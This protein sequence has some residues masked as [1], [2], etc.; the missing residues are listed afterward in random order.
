[1]SE[2]KNIALLFTTTT[3]TVSWV[4]YRNLHV[5]VPPVF[6]YPP[7]YRAVHFSVP[8]G[9]CEYASVGIP[10]R[11]IPFHDPCAHAARSGLPLLCVAK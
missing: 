5:Y 9:A 1:M 11:R 6:P 4:D 8:A 10:S 3:T 7:P 2:T